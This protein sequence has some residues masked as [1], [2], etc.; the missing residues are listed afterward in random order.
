MTPE[1]KLNKIINELEKLQDS[2]LDLNDKIK[3]LS[4]NHS[5]LSSS[6]SDLHEDIVS[7]VGDIHQNLSYHMNHAE[8]MVSNILH[9]QRLDHIANTITLVHNIMN[10]GV[11]Q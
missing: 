10:N 3:E 5:N 8:Q 9:P 1:D 2:T 11:Q 7:V 6:D 4:Y